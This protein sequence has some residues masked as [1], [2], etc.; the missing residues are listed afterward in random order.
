MKCQS[1]FSGKNKK[2]ISK[3]HLLKVLPSM[4][5][6]NM[7]KSYSLAVVHVSRFQRSSEYQGCQGKREHEQSRIDYQRGRTWGKSV[8]QLCRVM[9]SFSML[10]FDYIFLI[11]HDT[12]FHLNTAH[13]PVSAQSSSSIVFRLQLVYFLSV[14]L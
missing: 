3:C 9:F 10:V 4:L 13:S 5:S 2:N 11:S 12:L 14:S 1:L 7:L 6:L 8:I